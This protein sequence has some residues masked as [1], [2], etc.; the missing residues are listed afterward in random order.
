MILV[1][2]S[3]LFPT[4]VRYMMH[5]KIHCIIPILLFQEDY[6]ERERRQNFQRNPDGSITASFAQSQAFQMP[7]GGDFAFDVAE[8]I[9][10]G[11]NVI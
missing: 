7:G 2:P 5:T 3:V 4:N 8:T 1:V 11:P 9:N 10:I 6:K